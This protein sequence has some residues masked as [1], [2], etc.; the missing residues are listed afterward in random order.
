MPCVSGDPI[1]DIAD[2]QRSAD[3]A[4]RAACNIVAVARRLKLWG[5]IV[6]EI[7]N[8]TRDW[9]A[10]HDKADAER[11]AE[12]AAEREERKLRRKALS[13]LSRKERELLGVDED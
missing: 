7:S 2:A 12:E 13:K 3:R 9:L 1:D 5:R 11:R 4:T 6:A 10:E 8:A